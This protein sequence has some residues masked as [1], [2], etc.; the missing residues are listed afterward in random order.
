[1]RANSLILLFFCFLPLS[2]NKKDKE[3]LETTLEKYDVALKTI[4]SNTLA[5]QALENDTLIIE[6][7]IVHTSFDTLN[8]SSCLSSN[9]KLF[10][11]FTD[12]QCSV[13]LDK[14]FDFI[15]KFKDSIGHDNIIILA[16]TKSLRS[17]STLIRQKRLQVTVFQILNYNPIAIQAKDLNNPFYFISNSDAIINN[18]HVPDKD[19]GQLTS[20]YFK[21]VVMKKINH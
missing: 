21:E 11:H 5:Q 18:V 16:N 7:P 9:N 15:N 19:M 17:I 20:E 12:L 13:C 10:F 8:L 3:D 6:I 1:M 4:V 14:Q 2:C